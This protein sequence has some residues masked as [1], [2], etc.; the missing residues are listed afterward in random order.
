MSDRR[1]SARCAFTLVELLV[2]IGIIALLISILLPSLANAREQ[3]NS[4]KC[5]SNLRQLAQAAA[6]YTSQNKGYQVPGDLVDQKFI[7][8]GLA[9]QLDYNETWATIL[10]AHGF[11]KYPAAPSTTTPPMEDNILR[12]PSGV[13]EMSA[14][15]FVS[16]TVPSSR[17][18]QQGA[19]AVLHTSTRLLPGTNVFSWYGINSSST[20]GNKTPYVRWQ[21]NTNGGTVVGSSRK[22]NEIRRS[23]ETVFLF[24]GL[25]GMNYMSTNANRINARHNKQK[26]T[27]FA[28]VDGH[29]ESLWTKD[30]PGGAPPT[31][32]P[33]SVFALTNL[34]NYPY[35]KWFIN[36]Q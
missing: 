17:L 20:V 10:L 36:Q 34:V 2:V 22:A 9:Y 3:G 13:L 8:T 21:I 30:L 23:T 14:V 24:D 19:M 4:I 29:A 35:P 15:T 6:M 32:V 26:V 25:L 1:G 7:P 33:T 18:D 28:F 5:L 12:C 11:I 27:N 31:S 16:T